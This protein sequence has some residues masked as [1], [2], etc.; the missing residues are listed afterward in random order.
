MPKIPSPFKQFVCPYC[1]QKYSRSE[2]LYV[3]QECKQ[4][5]TPGITDWNKIS[6]QCKNNAPGTKRPCGGIAALRVCPR[7]GVDKNGPLIAQGIDTGVIPNEA[8]DTRNLPFSIVGVSASGKTNY[9][10]VMLEELKRVPGLRLAVSCENNYTRDAHEENRRAI[11]DEHSIP[12][13]TAAGTQMPQLWQI[14]NVGDRRGD[15]IPSL[16]LTIYDG[17]GE[18]HENINPTSNVCKYI[19]A[20]SA[21]ILTLDPLILRNLRKDINPTILANSG[22]RVQQHSAEEI[23]SSVAKYIKIA[24]GVPTERRLDVPVAVVLTKFDTILN[25]RLFPQDALVQ[26]PSL[27]VI[28][29]KINSNEFR[30]VDQEIRDWLYVINEGAFIDA[31]E[32]DFREFQFFGVSSYGA[33][34][35]AVGVLEEVIRPHRV[36]DPILWLLQREKFIN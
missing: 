26:S 23:V 16:T 35:K 12:E 4:I 3:C 17:A 5:T 15:M 28:D 19:N 34:P 22:G 36:L 10:T 6:I 33:P 2:I 14:K 7:C 24:R 20:S 9:I 8:L 30:Q 27:S 29:G 31:I 11:Y 1:F 13:L 25:H 21:I 32:A 18:D